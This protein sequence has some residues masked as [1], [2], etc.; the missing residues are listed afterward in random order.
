LSRR[1]AF[2]YTAELTGASK[3]A[4]LELGRTLRAYRDSLVLVGGWVP[5]LLIERHGP[6]ASEFLHVGSIDIGFVV[7][8]DRIGENE[9]AT[10]VELI[11]DVGWRPCAGKRFS[12]ERTVAGSDGKPYDVQVDFLTPTPG[13]PDQSH[14]HRP[15]Q[16]DLQA[17]T[18]RGAEL[19][20]SHRLSIHL[21]GRLPN[22]ADSNA[23]VLMLDVTGCL[24]TKAIALGDRYKQKDA[25]DIV[26]LIDRY[27]SGIPEVADLVRPSSK[28]PL[29][30]E[31]LDVLRNKFQTERSEGPIWYAEFL[32]GERDALDRAA[33]RAFQ[34]VRE[35]D[36][37]LG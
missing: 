35:F 29:L 22:G 36:R 17:R 30:A 24:G 12:F 15:V 7:D 23:D 11:S 2:E 8:P 28:E 18:M 33:Q 10:I 9:Y 31:A 16:V 14:R 3:V 20:L 27:G 37:L 6:S 34:V 19:A 25:Y 21:A 32:G 26:S 13:G 5:Y 4:L 1:L